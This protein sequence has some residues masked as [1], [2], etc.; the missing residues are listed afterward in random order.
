[1]IYRKLGN[2]T[3]D[4]SV[5]CLGTMTFGEQN[6]E[7]EAHE[8]IDFSLDQ[9]VNFI[10]TAELYPVPPKNKTQGLTEEYIGSWLQ[11]SKKR[12]KIIL[13]SKVT[14]PRKD[15]KYISENLGFSKERIVEAIHLSL[16]RLKTDYLDLYQLH[17]PERKTNYFGVRGYS[18]HDDLWIDNFVEA[19]GTLETLKKAGKIRHYGLSN[20]TPW[21]IHRV[22]SLARQNGFDLPVSIQNPYSL[23]NRLYEVGLSEISIR[24]NMGLLAYS[25]LAMG[26]LSGKYNLGKDSPADRL[27]KYNFSRY[28]KENARLAVQKYLELSKEYE[29]SLT[30]M[31][32]AFINQQEFVTSTIIGATNMTQL[33]EN[34]ASI[35]LKLDEDLIY[36]INKIHELIPNPAP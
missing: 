4:V 7:K 30:Q 36:K 25:P 1:M 10:D 14:G 3:I 12:S 31:S 6:S 22:I 8:Q 19:I 23:L 16:N 33:R 15:V 2:T 35:K 27:N 32:L 26:L 21:G 29:I 34:I 9:G 5:I 28:N 17:W 18:K 20:E 24:E 13:A 11:K